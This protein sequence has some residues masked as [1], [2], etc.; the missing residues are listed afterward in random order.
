[1]TKEEVDA[2]AGKIVNDF[3]T[4][5]DER[6]GAEGVVYLVAVGQGPGDFQ[7]ATNVT[8]GSLDALLSLVRTSVGT[9]L[10]EKEFGPDPDMP[11]AG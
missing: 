7:I 10:M 2:I 6:L 3:M 11:R 1:M 5:H 9:Y 8:L 4:E